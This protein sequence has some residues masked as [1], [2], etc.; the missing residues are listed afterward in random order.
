MKILVV[1]ISDMHCNAGDGKKIT[2]FVQAAQILRNSFGEV[3]KILIVFSGDLTN[4]AATNEFQAAKTLLGK[5][6]FELSDQFKCGFIDTFIVPGNHDMDLP[7]DCRDANEIISWK[8]DDHLTDEQAR[9][10]N[11]YEY[12][13]SKRCFITNPICDCRL[14]QI[15]TKTLQICLLNSALF[16]TRKPNDKEL[17]FFPSNVG[18]MLKRSPDADIKITVMHH[19]YE[20]C[21]W[22]TK[23][24]IKA[25]MSDDD[26]VFFGHDHKA[27][28]IVLTN[29]NGTNY[30]IFIGG[31]F[32]LDLSD[33]CA[34]N[35]VLIESNTPKMQRCEFIWNTS[36][37][38]FVKKKRGDISKK[39]KSLCPKEEYLDKMLEDRQRLSNRF[40]DYYALPNLE[41]EGK[42]F[43]GD[44]F[45]KINVDLIFEALLNERAIQVS[46]GNGVGKSALL[47]YLYLISISKGYLPLLIEK[48]DYR[49]S[50]IDKMFRDMFELQ[51]GI[52]IECGY[53]MY[54]Q[55]SLDSRIVFIDDFDQI[56]NEKARENLFAYV[57]EKGGLLIYSTKEKSQD[58]E[59]I[60]KDK[61]QG[62]S[63][64]AIKICPFFKSSR[65]ELIHRI[66]EI[67]KCKEENKTTI[68]A[69]LDYM[70]QSQTNFFSLTPSTLIQYV[71]FFLNGGTNEGKGIKTITLVFETNIRNSIMLST[72]D[73]DVGIYLA[74]LEYIADYMY[75]EQQK[76]QFS[77]TDLEKITTSFNGQRKAAVNPKY[78][79]HAC[80]KANIL[81]ECDGSFDISFND[82]ETF[83]YFVAKYINRA[84]EK[85]FSNLDRVTYIM[86][87][88][89]FGIND[90]IILFLSYIRSN[91]R[92]ILKIATE[93]DTLLADI[94]EWSI[95]D[96]NLPFLE[97]SDSLS[98]GLPS[99]SERE[100]TVAKTEELEK[101]KLEAVH[102]RGIFDFCEEDVE[103]EQYRILRA[104]KYTQLIGR[105]LADQYGTLDADDIDLM[106]GALYSIPQKIVYAALKPYQEHY[107][108]VVAD[109]LDFARREMPDEKITE[110]IVMK[111]FGEAGVIL[112][113][114]ILNDIAYN[115][116][117]Q[118]TIHAL[119]DV[120]L[121][122]TNYS[123][124][125]LMME[126]NT[127]DTDEF[128][129]KVLDFRDKYDSQHF[130]K[131][132][133]AQIARKHIIYNP[134]IDYRQVDKL[135]SAKVLSPQS[136]KS[137]LI[138]QEK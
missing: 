120:C 96:K 107:G 135:V 81:K 58:L 2:K 39:T 65:D 117:D 126:E 101:A 50:R 62:K 6:L 122:K 59:K 49:D 119:R 32:A 30:N 61:L 106:V 82:K 104:L 1:Q 76:E 108:D 56:T 25:S 125:Q 24:M 133:A 73:K 136:K 31:K 99:S 45:R 129:T 123:V 18:E 37:H 109:I 29:G 105:A 57:I 110:S 80:I 33:E 23:E 60:V 69:A 75:F 43:S 13:H 71:K 113:L 138:E 98:N 103:K 132:V 137:L 100:K 89:C 83:A 97:C 93:A 44:M 20:C 68:I 64:C 130:V 78:F 28:S 70:V 16:S 114:N 11:F 134:D 5:F 95:D 9:L 34:F 128:V 74:L 52:D 118:N 14:I 27:E 63:I 77:I 53:E 67:T 115:A 127:G 87:H 88:I 85:D 121:D 12:A 131:M 21:D 72:K 54:Q 42:T 111:M 41:A 15:G 94:P 7:D 112:A 4:T 124:M 8:K 90:A 91:T 22:D 17:H 19:S 55:S 66:C 86:R 36:Q 38:I 79:L 35:A 48:Q 84:L 47:R 102:F 26:I 3:D 10:K 51:Y 92:I 40:T 46:G 116:A